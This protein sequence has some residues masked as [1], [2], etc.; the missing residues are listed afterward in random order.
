MTF[1]IITETALVKRINRVLARERIR[2]KKTGRPDQPYLFVDLPKRPEDDGRLVLVPK[3]QWLE[4]ANHLI[5]LGRDLGVL[6]YDE[7]VAI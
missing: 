2:L 5:D 1:R 7:A 3:F 4:G 6:G